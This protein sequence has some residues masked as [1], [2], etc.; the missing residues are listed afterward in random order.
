[1]IFGCDPRT[2]MILGF[3]G[4]Q[5]ED[6]GRFID[7]FPNDGRYVV[8]ARIAD[9]ERY[10]WVYDHIAQHVLYDGYLTNG[11]EIVFRFKKPT[12]AY[13]LPDSFLQHFESPAA[14]RHTVDYLNTCQD[15][16]L[17]RTVVG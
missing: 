6:F 4:Y 15:R 14:A 3:L 12:E 2:P 1:M 7:S 17:E 9:D 8:V 5:R 11:A 13:S 16:P 10:K